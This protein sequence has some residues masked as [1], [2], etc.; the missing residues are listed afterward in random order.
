MEVNVHGGKVKDRKGIIV[1]LLIISIIVFLPTLFFTKSLSG[2]TVGGSSGQVET[3][4]PSNGNLN[5]G[6]SGGG[7][8][9]SNTTTHTHNYY[10][11]IVQSKYLKWAATCTAKAVYYYSCECGE[12]GTQTFEYG[13]KLPHTFN[14]QI[15]D[16]IYLKSA[17]TCTAKATYY[18]SCECGEK[19]E[20]T[21]EY[22]DK[23]PHTF[24]K[25][26]VDETY[27][28]SAAT[29]TAKA[30]YYYSCKCGEKG[31]VTFEYG[32]P[33]PHEFNNAYICTNCSYKCKSDG[34]SFELSTDNNSYVCTGLGT[35]DGKILI[36][37][38]V[39]N[40][41]PVTKIEEDAFKN[42]TDITDVLIPDSITEVG[43]N[44]FGGC[45]NLTKMVLPF[46][47][48]Y[49][50][51]SGDE[52]I[53]YIFGASSYSEQGQKLPS[54]L[55]TIVLSDITTKIGDYAFYGCSSLTNIT[56]PDGM[57][58][59]GD[60]AFQ[61][62]SSLTRI[63]YNGDVNDWVQIDGLRG[64]MLCV[65]SNKELY[66]NGELLTEA[67]IDTAAEIK[68]NAFYG[69]SS[70]TSV[71]IGNGVTSID[72]YAF[73]GCRLLTSITIPDSVT[74]I[75]GYAFNGCTSLT[76]VTIGNGVTS[77]GQIAFG[78]CTSLTS[79]TIGDSV[80]SIEYN[81]FYGCT[82]LQ[83]N[84]Y[85]NGLYLGNET[86]KYL[87]LIKPKTQGIK[88]ITINNECKIIEGSS[89]WTAN[90]ALTGCSFLESIIIP[91]SVTSIGEWAFSGCYSLTNV[92][93]GDSVTSIG[94]SAFS[95][96]SKLTN[97]TI[98]DSVTSIGYDAFWNCS[99]LKTI[100]YKGSK[101]QWDLISK[102]TDWNSNTG[103]Y[104]INY[105]YV[106]N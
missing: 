72:W 39:Y 66:I 63:Y 4:N 35:F 13:D 103:S 81:A 6:T 22:G 25:Q 79:V 106:E 99:L 30:V 101:E 2:K 3:N 65:S 71:T 16:E 104:I 82:S 27:L 49:A 91:N 54:P 19:G 36:I 1:A 15:V 50:D 53:G 41:K 42:A 14:K 33:L 90:G 78:H 55:K 37:P 10:K 56:I 21:F 51:G 9:N 70:L 24:N 80:T 58:S 96:C 61:G 86:N 20:Q 76:S 31:T 74:N 40:G 29:C 26:I 28:K 17:A 94:S 7:N 52:N 85:D 98:P 48:A 34:L 93:I 11:E 87:V 8:G 46:V 12:K 62:C 60:Y 23:L 67:V 38:S 59:V 77:I 32:E 83:F 43:F 95:G 64:L 97:I 102:G 92:T 5:G 18:Y 44:A 47:G 45:S 105:N 89:D 75:A 100:N 68:S 57:I 69:C 88:N 84:R 73:S